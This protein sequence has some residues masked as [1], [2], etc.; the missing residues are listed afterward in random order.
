M[1][2]ASGGYPHIIHKEFLHRCIDGD[3]L[4]LVGHLESICCGFKELHNG[5]VYE[6]DKLVLMGFC[7]VPSECSLKSLEIQKTM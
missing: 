3:F 7:K 4:C 2:V 6:M 1:D 5:L